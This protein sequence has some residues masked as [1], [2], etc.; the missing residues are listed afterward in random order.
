MSPHTGWLTVPEWA[1]VRQIEVRRREQDFSPLPPTGAPDNLHV[2]AR[3]VVTLGEGDYRLRLTADDH[4]QLWLNGVYT[5]QGPAPA[6]PERYPWLT[7]PLTGGQTVTVALHLYYQGLVNRVWNSGDGRFGLWAELT[8]PAGEICS[9]DWRYQICTA[10]SGAPLG[11]DTQLLEDFDSRRYPEGWEQPGYDD[12]A[13]G[14]LVPALWADYHLIPQ[15]TEPLWEG[16]T[17]PTEVRPIPG[18]LLLDFGREIAGTLHLSAR[19]HAGQIVTLRLG[20]ELENGRV[21]YELRCNCRYEE[22]WTLD[23][24]D[25]TL[26]PY[27]YKAFRYAEVLYPE[28]VEVG[29]LHARERH[30]PMDE[31][32]STLRCPTDELGDIFTI[33][34]NAV[35]CCTQ[36]GFVDC[37]TREKGQYLGDAVITARSHLWLTGDA[38]MLRK[39]I[40]DF[41]ASARVS[42]TLM[43]VAPGSLMQ[44]IGDYSL[45]FPQ[46]VWT[47]W[48]FTG[49]RAFLGE[50]LP[51]ISAML[52]AFVAK[53][54]RPDGLLERVDELWNLVDWP[55]NLRDGY[56]FPLTRPIV[57]PGVHNVINALWYGALTAEERMRSV[58]GLPEKNR[59]DRARE[60]FLHTFY[61]PGQRLFADSETS[62]H[63]SLHANLY[64]ACFGLL[65]EEGWEAYERLLCTPGRVCGVLPMYFALRGLGRMGKYE[66]LYRLVTRTDEYGW[67]NMLREGATACFEAWGK[68]Q[69]WNTSL[70]HPWA[71]GAIPLIVEELA[72]LR[73]DPDNAE[74]FR[75]EPHLPEGLDGF[76]LQVPF[77]GSLLNVT[78]RAG[79]LPALERME[80]VCFTQ[81]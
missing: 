62:D 5:G 60:A 38:A 40:R 34:K 30:Y 10:Y 74:G 20:E 36:E 70:C 46:L 19:G 56:D 15:E 80:L 76:T 6:Y 63:C 52:D 49:D 77:R 41:L 24:G 79:E 7:Y 29:H 43:A 72:G 26:H 65:P 31:R 28:D 53:W 32:L 71:S 22:R 67:R 9:I 55:D 48:E 33:C 69:K 14:R 35:R 64:A 17:E 8:G 81:N 47:D 73:P 3:G 4:Y 25:N 58:L 68:E 13:W 45:L 54:Q 2:L 39:C 16:E 1:A 51:A 37:C 21:R 11:Y 61:R 12:S 18:G 27:D 59:S 75:F 57:G 78:K 66:T 23:E 50:C 44:E 42:P